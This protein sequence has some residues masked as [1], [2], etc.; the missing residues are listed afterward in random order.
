MEQVKTVWL[1]LNPADAGVEVVHVDAAPVTIHVT[2]P[3]G[4]V[5]P[6]IPV[7]VAV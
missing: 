1:A 7:T 6:E 5:A 3:A 2:V 4:R